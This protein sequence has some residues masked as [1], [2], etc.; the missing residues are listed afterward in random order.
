M[1]TLQ[2]GDRAPGFALPDQDGK[3][4]RSADFPGHRYFVF[5]YPKANTSGCASRAQSVRD[6]RPGL[7]KRGIDKVN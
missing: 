3:M 6:A 7:E 2:P 1:A 5:S 4:V